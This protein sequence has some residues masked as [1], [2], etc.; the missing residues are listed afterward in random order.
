MLLGDTIAAVCTGS[1][2][3]PRAILRLSGPGVRDAVRSLTGVDPLPGGAAA[4]LALG[5]RTVPV[6][7]S[8]ARA[9]RS[10]TGED[11]AEVQFPGGPALRERVLAAVLAL[12]GVRYAEAGEFSARAYLNRKL[13]P[14]QAEG[15]AAVIAARGAR[16]LDAAR[17]LLSGRTGDAYRA[18]ADD[19]ATALALVE[20]G[21]DFS[22]QEDV[23]AVS[24]PDLLARLSRVRDR[25][26]ELLGGPGGAVGVRAEPTIVIAG[27]P[28]AGKSALFNALLGMRRAVV[29][30][31]AG[32]TRDAVRERL[33]VGESGW[34]AR[35][36]WLVDLAGLDEALA[37]RSAV[38][39]AGQ[40]RALEEIDRAD[41]ILHCVPASEHRARPDWLGS[42]PVLSVRT[43]ADLP[44]V[45]ARDADEVP[46]CAV[47]GWNVDELKATIAQRVF[48]RAS[49]SGDESAVW[50]RHRAALERALAGVARVADGLTGLEEA[51][52]LPSPELIAADLRD[53]LDELG[54]VSGRIAPDEVIGR[55]FSTFCVGK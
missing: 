20:A 11:T 40:T 32:T 29:S 53:A 41:L 44:G 26:A 15:V 1:A 6:L 33:T 25:L 39:R 36:A 7:L 27:A 35:S 19:L 51:D 30:P 16:E 55:V 24:A 43:K 46:V 18:V 22:D 12:P 17:H 21:I 3:G 5:G 34:D 37:A 42:R 23:R 14:E 54:S 38:D 10:F 4:R 28:N 8:A 47:D 52:P 49:L 31:V 48:G 9:P 45:D 50:P 2:P 13:T